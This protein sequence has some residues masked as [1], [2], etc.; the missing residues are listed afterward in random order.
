MHFGLNKVG[1]TYQCTMQKEFKDKISKNLEVYIDDLLVKTKGK[2]ELIFDLT[3][4]FKN[5]H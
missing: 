2:D 5:L 1:A 4:T 3:E